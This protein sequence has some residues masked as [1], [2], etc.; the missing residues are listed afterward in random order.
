MKSAHY[1]ESSSFHGFCSERCRGSAGTLPAALTVAG[2]ATTARQATTDPGRGPGPEKN[3]LTTWSMGLG[4][5]SSYSRPIPRSDSW[6]CGSSLRLSK[7]GLLTLS[8]KELLLSLQALSSIFRAFSLSPR[9]PYA[10]ASQVPGTYS[11]CRRLLQL[12]EHL[13]RVSPPIRCH[14]GPDEDRPVFRQPP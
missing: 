3:G 11:S 1:K 7:K 8:G 2:R 9:A 4:C 6:K 10:T 13:F 14:V 12:F 5:R